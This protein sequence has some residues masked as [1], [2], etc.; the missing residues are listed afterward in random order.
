[1]S[2]S[3]PGFKIIVLK[4]KSSNSQDI[5]KVVDYA[6]R[7]LILELSKFKK[8]NMM[9]KIHSNL[10]T[11]VFVVPQMVTILYIL[12]LVS[13]IISPC[14]KYQAYILKGNDVQAEILGLQ[15]IIK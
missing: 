13:G 8:K 9:H 12:L 4:Y 6:F 14:S 2:F 1:M 10:A 11:D 3:L 15:G 7:Y 5:T